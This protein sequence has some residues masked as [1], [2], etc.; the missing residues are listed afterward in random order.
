MRAILAWAAVWGDAASLMGLAVALVGFAL[1]LVNVA[2]SRS[3]AE[4]A[5]QAANNARQ[6]I[7]Y[8]TSIA[9]LASALAI[10]EEIKRLQR[11]NAWPVIPD[12]Y[13]ILRL[14][15]ISI[16]STTTLITEDQRQVLQD[17]IVQLAELEQKVERALARNTTP[18]N[19][20]KLNEIVS[21]LLGQIHLVLSDLQQQLRD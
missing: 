21:S 2:R 4:R 14:K 10:L 15:L 6:S 5:E 7:R 20:A 1:T 11:Q 19:P 9:E 3:A 13:S 16:R 18:P 8:V 17:A 12:R